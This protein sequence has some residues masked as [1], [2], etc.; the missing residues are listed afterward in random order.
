MSM[1][2]QL[3]P[4]RAPGGPSSQLLAGLPIALYNAAVLALI[5]HVASG[6]L[7]GLRIAY[8]GFLTGAATSVVAMVLRASEITAMARGAARRHAIQLMA[9]TIGATVAYG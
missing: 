9:I 1:P 8:L 5:V 3:P 7:L 4:S 6:S 2:T